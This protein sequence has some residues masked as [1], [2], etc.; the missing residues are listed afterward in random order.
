[1]Y[2]IQLTQPQAQAARS[3]LSKAVY[4][5][6]FDWIVLRVNDSIRGAASDGI[7][8]ARVEPALS[9]PCALPADQ[10]VDSSHLTAGMAFIGLL[11]VFG[12]E[13][14]EVNLSSIA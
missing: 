4:C 1:M 3:A 6:L 13:I 12:F 8:P 7:R 9:R 5:L 11:D 10:E 14:F 2:N